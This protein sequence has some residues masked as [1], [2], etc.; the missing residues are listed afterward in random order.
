M[1]KNRKGIVVLL[2]P[3][4][5]SAAIA[6]GPDLVQRAIELRSGSSSIRLL[7]Y[8]LSVDA[9]I[10]EGPFI[11]LGVKPRTDEAFIPIG[12]HSTFISILVRGGFLGLLC[13]IGAF[14]FIPAINVVKLALAYIRH[15]NF[16]EEFRV[17]TRCVIATYFGCA[18][19]LVFQDVDAYASIAALI[20]AYFGVLNGLTASQNRHQLRPS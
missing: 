18:M 9:V 7:V 2:L 12:S 19:F 1:I 3:M 5:V 14:L 6:F 15:N 11:G 16:D 10:K 4:V 13:S 20:F 17:A 8:K